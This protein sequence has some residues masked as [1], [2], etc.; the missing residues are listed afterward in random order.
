[1][2][3]IVL[4]G[5]F[6]QIALIKEIK[7][8]G[9][10]TICVDYNE[11]PVAKKYADKYYQE[12]TLNTDK[13]K[14]IAIKEKVDFIITACT[15]Q[16]LLTMAKVSEELGLPCYIDYQTALNVTNKQYM[17]NV[18]MKN[19]IPTAKFVITDELKE[20]VISSFKYPII[21]KPV[22]CN[23]S[24]GVKKSNNYEELCTYFSEAKALSR[25]STAI[26]EEFISGEEL[27]IDVYVENGKVR[28]LSISASQ[29]ITSDEK[30][31]IWNSQYP[32]N[33][34]QKLFV[35]IE[36]A[37]QRIADSFKLINSPM[38]VQL[39]TDGEN[40]NIIEFS[41]RTGG[42]VKYLLVKRCSGFDVI[43]AVVD[44]TLNKKPHC[45]ELVCEC[46]Y[47]INAFIY[48]YPGEFDHLE[49]FEEL[50][51][52]GV[53]TDYYLF[54]NKGAIFDSI[55]NSGDRIAGITIQS[56]DY[57]DFLNKYQEANSKLKVIDTKGNDI[58]RHD[59]FASY[60]RIK[61]DTND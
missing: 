19:D 41:A 60:R 10:D 38:L 26:V 54:K 48:C 45:D 13:I 58:M 47:G 22:D 52:E 49:G 27:S 34:S 6:P 42:A 28:I 20:N 46:K 40:I 15:D 17:K 1:M 31:V 23:S 61:V 37:I 32:L 14:E 16:A 2:K 43:K 59:I 5:G 36:K 39:L 57:N 25:T 24:K 44:L 4:A 53:L 30:F 18:F 9:I 50:A 56:N 12:S 33:V 55:K 11:N 21:T 51:D 29:K 7:S 8:R 3:C 35:K